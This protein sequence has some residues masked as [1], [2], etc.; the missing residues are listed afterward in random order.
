MKESGHVL[1]MSPSFFI[2]HASSFSFEGIL[3]VVVTL[4]RVSVSAFATEVS[5]RIAAISNAR[6]VLSR[7]LLGLALLFVTS[8]AQSQ[9]TVAVDPDPRVAWLVAHAVKLHSVDPADVDFA[10]LKPLR[11]TLKGVRVVLL[12]E[13][14]HGD[15]T[16][17]L[18]KTR[19]IRFLHEQMGFDVL[20]FESGFYD[21]PKAWEL[22]TNG[23]EPRKAVPKG[24]FGVL[25]LTREFQPM[26]DYLG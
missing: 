15:G 7:A 19:L 18:A 13:Q 11:T 17:L 1:G 16:T 5:G 6:S 12:G 26:I 4:R 10:D 21:C 9:E 23:E 3:R 24:V 2:L 8:S 22:L 20:A 14:D 25:T